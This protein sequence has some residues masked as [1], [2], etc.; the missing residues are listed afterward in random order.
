M[1]RIRPYS[2]FKTTRDVKS[3]ETGW[4]DYGKWPLKEDQYQKRCP[5]IYDAF[6]SRSLILV[7]HC[8]TG[9]DY[10]KEGDGETSPDVS[11]G[12]EHIKMQS[13]LW[14][15]ADRVLK[16]LRGSCKENAIEVSS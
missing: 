15:A 8:V 5:A 3:G 1:Q 11:G 13:Q 4:T 9:D 10:W 12:T 16:A 14:S 6:L 7:F 2:C